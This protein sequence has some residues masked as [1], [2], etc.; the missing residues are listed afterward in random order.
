MSA[1]SGRSSVQVQEVLEV[2]EPRIEVGP[3]RGQYLESTGSWSFQGGADAAG[4]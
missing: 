4:P 1:K 3:L 2:L